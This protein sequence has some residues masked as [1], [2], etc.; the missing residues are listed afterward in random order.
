MD[1]YNSFDCFTDNSF[2][3]DEWSGT[4]LIDFDDIKYALDSLNLVGRKIRG[5][6]FIGGEYTYS[7]GDS[8]SEPEYDDTDILE[9]CSSIDAP[10][11]IF[12]EDGDQIEVFAPEES[13]FRLSMNRIPY[14]T[15]DEF[16]IH[17]MDADI[18]YAPCKGCIVTDVEI[19]DYHS[20]NIEFKD[21][22]HPVGNHL[23]KYIT[24][25]FNDGN[26]LKLYGGMNFF[27]IEYVNRDNSLNKI[28][29]SQLKEAVIYED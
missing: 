9:R 17:N 16:Q 8:G 6:K 28:P 1:K 27:E 2:D 29:Y 3:P 21:N 22:Y 20:E 5:L 25:R 14:D 11:I 4:I 7:L 13:V 26:G 10:L 18:L 12:F 24:L 15:E 23:V 19:G